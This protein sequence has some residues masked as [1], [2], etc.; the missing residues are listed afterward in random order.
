[1]RF[2]LV[3]AIAARLPI[4]MVRTAEIQITQNQ[5]VPACATT[6]RIRRNSANAAALGPVDIIAVT[7]AGAPS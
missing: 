1:M 3:C 2:T 4:N 5:M 6:I 7:G